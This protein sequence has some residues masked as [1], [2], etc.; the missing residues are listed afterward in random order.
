MI[1][2]GKHNARRGFTLIELLVVISIIALLI[3]ILLPSLRAARDQA[4]KVKCMAN[5]HAIGLAL[6]SYAETNRQE[7]PDYLGMGAWGFRMAPGTQMP[8]DNMPEVFGVQGMLEA[9]TAPERLPNGLFRYKEPGRPVYLAADSDVWECPGNP[10][11]PGYEDEWKKW[12]N[13]Y[14]YRQNSGAVPFVDQ[15]DGNTDPNDDGADDDDDTVKRV[16]PLVYNIDW[17][18][19][20]TRRG[21]KNP[22]VWDNYYKLPGETGFMGPFE[23]DGYNI[24]LE[25]RVPPHRVIGGKRKGSAK[26]WIGFYA[27]GHCQINAYNH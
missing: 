11:L 15:D 23:G 9:G 21:A 24:D 1:R 18:N 2:F 13:S 3:A 6:Y 22:L 16:N 25:K 19:R 12:G 5:L 26:Y 17:L 10:G 20:T 7:L 27:A 14:T 4:R 8:D